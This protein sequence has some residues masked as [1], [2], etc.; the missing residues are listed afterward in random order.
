MKELRAGKFQVTEEQDVGRAEWDV[1][2]GKYKVWNYLVCNKEMLEGCTEEGSEM[3]NLKRE[4]GNKME[5]REGD[6]GV[7]ENK[8][9]TEPERFANLKY[10]ER[11]HCN[12]K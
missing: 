11:D 2:Y 6:S 9:T 7:G 10:N 5:R 4:T 8:S 12:C 1:E 3:I